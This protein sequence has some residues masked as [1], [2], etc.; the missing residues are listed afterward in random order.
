MICHLCLDSIFGY[1]HCIIILS[2]VTLFGIYCAFHLKY[3]L[4]MHTGILSGP[5]GFAEPFLDLRPTW[6]PGAPRAHRLPLASWSARRLDVQRTAAP[7]QVGCPTEATRVRYRADLGSSLSTGRSLAKAL[8]LGHVS[9]KERFLSWGGFLG[10]G[11]NGHLG[12]GL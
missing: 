11:V 4:A 5:A 7:G 1:C 3:F 10:E 8:C 2:I 6:H 9:T 12:R